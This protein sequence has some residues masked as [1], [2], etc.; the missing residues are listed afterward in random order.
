[1][2]SHSEY[3]EGIVRS[4]PVQIRIP[5]AGIADAPVLMIYAT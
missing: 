3:N 4:V 5:F 2:P 1:V